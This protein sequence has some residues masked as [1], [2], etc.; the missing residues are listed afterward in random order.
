MSSNETERRRALAEQIVRLLAVKTDLGASLLAGSVAHGTCDE[1]SDIDLLNYYDVL[2]D[3]GAFDAVLV[4]LGGKKTGEIVPPN[5]GGFMSSYRID[6][7]EVQTGGQLVSGM[8][9]Q[10]DQIGAGEVN[11]ATAK[12]AMGL[13]EG[14]PLHGA[15][16]IATWKDRVAYPETVRRRE[17]ESNLGFF[18]IWKA[19]KQLIN[20]EAELFRRQ[21]LLDG[22]FRVVAVLSA[23]NRLYF[24]TFQ[25]KRAAT[26]A[27]LM[28]VK[29]DRLVERLDRVANAS[30]AEAAVELQSLVDETKA[31]VANEIPDVNVDVPWRPI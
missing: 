13:L 26:H 29:P 5:P 24:S 15:D 19:D 25:F 10:V 2:P 20:R 17:L 18:P 31:I 12:V 14:I 28:A 6:G 11:W 21:M 1:L 3:P 9:G 8:K 16:L 23:V 7:I 4:E 22:A 27:G 30:P